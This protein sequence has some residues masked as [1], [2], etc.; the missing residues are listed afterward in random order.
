MRLDIYLTPG[1]VVPG[2]IAERTVVVLDILRATTTIAEA[3][4]NGARSVYPVSSIEEALRLANTFGRDE[5]LLCGER[6]CLPIEG[7]DLGNS[8]SEFTRE[9]VAGKILVMTTTNGTAALSLTG[10]ASRVLVGSLLNLGAVVA[11]LAR[12]RAEPVILCSGRDRH[13]ALEDA[14]VAGAMAGRLMDALP[15]E[16][17]LNDAALAAIALARE[18]GVKASTFRMCESGRALLAAGHDPDLD[19]CAQ[20]DTLNVLP[21]LHER[22]ITLSQAPAGSL[23]SS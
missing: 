2:E 12:S 20:I 10:G 7:F 8:P 13:F 19:F 4:N 21:V 18:F 23:P 17:V 22:N 14:V 9:R 15:G 16:W 1:E 3:L 6:K 5:V 11:E